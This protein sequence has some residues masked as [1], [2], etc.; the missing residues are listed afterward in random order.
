MDRNS[1]FANFYVI[2]LAKDGENY[3][4]TEL[5]PVDVN[6]DFE[7]SCDYYVLIYRDLADK[8]Y[9]ENAQIGGIVVI[10]GD[11][12]SGSCNLEFK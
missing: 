5:K 1:T 10:N 2:K 7:E 8:T 11:P 6:I 4:I 3:K 12:T 9:F